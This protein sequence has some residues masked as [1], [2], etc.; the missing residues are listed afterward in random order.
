MRFRSPSVVNPVIIKELRSRMRGARAFLILTGALFLLG[1]VSYALYRIIL[2]TSRY[3][4]SPLSPQIGQTLFVA[5]AF[6]ELMLVCFITPAVTAGTISGEREKLTYEMLLATPLRPASILWGKLISALSYVFL[7]IFA[8]VPM[9][10]LVFIFGGVAPRDMIKALIILV[11]VTVTLGVVGAFTS[12]WLGRTARAT[13][14]SYLV[15]LGLLIGPVFAYVL[16]G[17]LQQSEPPRWILVPNP[18]SALFSALSP[19]MPGDYLGGAFW[20]LGM[21][22][23]GNLRVLTGS[24]PQATIPRPLYHFTLPL[25]AAVTLALYLLTTRLVQP[26]HRWR[27]GL[28][29]TSIAVALFLLLGGAVATAFLSTADRYEKASTLITPTPVLPPFMPPPVVV[30]RAEAVG[31]TWPTPVPT[32]SSVAISPLPT[33]TF[34]PDEVQGVVTTLSPENS[35]PATPTAT[36]AITETPTPGVTVTPTE[37][38]GTPTPTPVLTEMELRTWS[39]ASPDGQW[40]AKGL[41]AFPK[42]G[43][44]LYYIQLTVHSTDGTV[45][46]TAVDEW[47]RFGLGYTTPQPFHWSREGRYLYFTNEPVPDGCGVFVNGSDLHKVDLSNGDVTEVVPSSGLW[48]SL[49]PDET[50]LAYIGYG[51]R[52]LVLRDL[53]TGAEREAKLAPGPDYA[54]GHVIW[55]PDG[56]ELVLTLAIRPCS[57]NWAESVSVVRVDVAT[58]QQT[59]LLEQD[60]RLFTTLEWPTLDRVLLKDDN[61][62]LWSMDPRTGQVT[63]HGG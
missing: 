4:R 58:L 38:A 48:L 21:S 53:A 44:E 32:E 47:T 37:V 62:A 7:L 57:A 9:A 22:L 12:A 33:S 31:P 60:R 61:G 5:I 50:M 8:A 49:S 30:E 26:T 36:P 59:T 15:V 28:K 24:G 54:A 16:V 27:I 18:A 34:L 43:G 39:S 11:A 52:G 3:T 10:S 63:T 56:T 45:E 20:G 1:A 41:A 2:S 19:S 6:L 51:D 14:V 25:Y 29:G 42:N 46:W 55:S 35:A 13:V 17:V 40:N 23:G